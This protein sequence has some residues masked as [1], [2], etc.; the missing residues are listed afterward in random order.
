MQWVDDK[1]SWEKDEIDEEI[2]QV[3]R[4]YK[5]F[6]SANLADYLEYLMKNDKLYLTDD[7]KYALTSKTVAYL[8]QR[9]TEERLKKRI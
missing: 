2:K 6:Y 4:Y 3:S 7:N 1:K 9:L 5:P 8:E